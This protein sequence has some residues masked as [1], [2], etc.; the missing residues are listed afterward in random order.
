MSLDHQAMDEQTRQL[1]LLIVHSDPSAFEELDGFRMEGGAL[2]IKGRANSEMSA[3]REALELAPDIVLVDV[4]QQQFDPFAVA[5]V[6]QAEGADVCVIFVAETADPQSLRRA[7]TCGAQEYL[8]KPLDPLVAGTTF[9]EVVYRHRQRQKVRQPVEAARTRPACE[10]LG[11]ISS[12]DGLGKTTIA[13]N[14]AIAMAQESGG[15]VALVDLGYGD[16][17][18][19]LNLAPRRSLEELVPVASEIDGEMLEEIALRHASGVALYCAHTRVD[20]LE[21]SLL[22]LECLKSFLNLLKAS[23]RIILV[24]ALSLRPG[25]DLQILEEFTTAL[26]VTTGWNLLE[27]R[28]TRALL[29]AIGGTSLGNRDAIKLVLNRSDKRD[30]IK[31]S[32]IEK[33]LKRSIYVEVANNS[34]LVLSSINLGQPVVLGEPESAVAQGVRELSLKLLGKSV[35]TQPKKGRG[36]FFK[37]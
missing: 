28:D 19:M 23:Y 27:L 24:D 16:A 7:L 33:N 17:G 1:D 21:P 12:R 20:Y 35:E 36:L 6:L 26:V 3:L 15:P 11:V 2:R 32:D 37:L 34:K 14:L 4:D 30:L 9:A 22:T 18:L 5:E 10:V 8:V 25:T 31:V 13:T 29:D